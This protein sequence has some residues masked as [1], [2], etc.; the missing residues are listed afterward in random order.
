LSDG[1]EYYNKRSGVTAQ[2][3]LKFTSENWHAA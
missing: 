1:A 2:N 3:Y